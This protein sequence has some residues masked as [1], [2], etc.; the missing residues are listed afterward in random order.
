M[1]PQEKKSPQKLNQT[2]NIGCKYLDGL[3][4]LNSRRYIL[5]SCKCPGRLRHPTSS[6]LAPAIIILSASFNAPLPI[7]S[8][9]GCYS[10]S[11]AHSDHFFIFLITKK[12]KIKIWKWYLFTYF[13]GDVQTNLWLCWGLKCKIKMNIEM[14]KTFCGGFVFICFSF[15]W[16]NTFKG[17]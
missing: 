11:D 15:L 3:F 7:F 10:L 4:C 2:T 5:E 13:G 1:V 14:R 9:V 16:I 8:S 17:D 12:I 6:H